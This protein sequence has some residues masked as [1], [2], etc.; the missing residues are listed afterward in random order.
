MTIQYRAGDFLRQAPLESKR[1][2]EI[3]PLQS[4]EIGGFAHAIGRSYDGAPTRTLKRDGRQV[5][6]LYIQKP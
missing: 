5:Y 2:E 1:H 4:E 6:A 3:L